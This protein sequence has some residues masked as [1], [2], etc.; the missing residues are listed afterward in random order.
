M[1]AYL[2]ADVT[3]VDDPA[4]Y[5]RYKPLVPPTLRA[6]GGT[7]LARSGP[8]TFLEG[9]WNPERI[10]IVRF[11]D[12]QQAM[13][14]WASEEYRDAKCLRQEATATNLIVVE[15]VSPGS[16]GPIR[17]S[18]DGSTHHRRAGGAVETQPTTP[19]SASLRDL[20]QRPHAGR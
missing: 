1:A 7:Y 18:G 11:D 15:G 5:D 9:T 4:L 6:Y 13:A 8:V 19:R 16:D 3:R 20:V 12:V 14:W 10:V 17:S 2:V